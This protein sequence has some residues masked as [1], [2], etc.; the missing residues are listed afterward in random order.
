MR[1]AGASYA[2]T[3]RMRA[4]KSSDGYYMLGQ[5]GAVYAFGSAKYYGSATGSWAVDL[6]LT[7]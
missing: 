1:S 3:V 4:L 6:M 7:P 5:N 2:P